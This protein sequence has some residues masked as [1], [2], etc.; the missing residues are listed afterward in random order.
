MY[1]VHP[2]ASILHRP[3]TGPRP[4]RLGKRK[5][6]PTAPRP[7]PT[8]CLPPT[9]GSRNTAAVHGRSSIQAYRAKPSSG[10]G[11]PPAKF[12]ERADARFDTRRAGRQ[13]TQK[14]ITLPNHFLL[15]FAD[16][17]GHIC[18][19]VCPGAPR[20]PH[21]AGMI[22]HAAHHGKPPFPRAFRGPFRSGRAGRFRRRLPFPVLP[23]RRDGHR[24]V[25]GGRGSEGLRPAAGCRAPTCGGSAMRRARNN[26]AP[27]TGKYAGRTGTLQFVC[28]RVVMRVASARRPGH[29]KRGRYRPLP[30][31]A[32]DRD[33][34]V[35]RAFPW[36]TRH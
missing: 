7:L 29:R 8:R 19:W 18:R 32:N 17:S 34:C 35:R 13:T 5:N 27:P 2:P 31:P 6:F 30:G 26:T 22:A 28:G 23:A 12:D 11:L 10:S 9:Y 16:E 1:L 20:G 3:S 15:S 36:E 4:T 33:F 24:A 21:G 25:T 14:C